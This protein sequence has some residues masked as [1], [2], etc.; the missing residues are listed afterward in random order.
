M[1]AKKASSRIKK[2]KKAA[3]ST[4]KKVNKAARKARNLLPL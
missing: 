1:M 4:V 3:K 2:A